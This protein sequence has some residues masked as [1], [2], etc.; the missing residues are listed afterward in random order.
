MGNSLMYAELSKST[1]G[2]EYV[3]IYDRY[4]KQLFKLTLPEF[5]VFSR[6]ANFANNR[7][8]TGKFKI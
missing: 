3:T 5:Q 2:T 8:E 6:W 7:I 4:K 1:D